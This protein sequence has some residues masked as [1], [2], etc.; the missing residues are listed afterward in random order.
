MIRPAPGV[1]AWLAVLLAGAGLIF[2][3]GY[4]AALRRGVAAYIG[5]DRVWRVVAWAL[6]R[7]AAAV[8]FFGFAVR[9][10]A[11]P[12]LA[13]FLGFLTARQVAVRTARGVS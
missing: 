3:W 13:A 2:G 4:F 5:H 7:I 12:L 9:W 10:G 8:L 11:W 1:E 6:V